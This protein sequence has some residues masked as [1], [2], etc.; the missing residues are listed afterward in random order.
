MSSYENDYQKE[1]EINN[2]QPNLN[3]GRHVRMIDL[4]SGISQ[5]ANDVG[6]IIHVISGSD[7]DNHID[8]R[9]ERNVC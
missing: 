3:G 6:S 7:V 1:K 2:W 9:L 8:G 4:A 5:P